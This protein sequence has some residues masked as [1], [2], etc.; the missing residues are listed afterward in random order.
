MVMVRRRKEIFTDRLGI[1]RRINED[2][3]ASKEALARHGYHA[4][5]HAPGPRT[6]WR[7]RPHC[8]IDDNSTQ[9]LAP[10]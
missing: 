7:I 4:I 6:Q 9:R 2:M 10:A 3:L 1:R 8:P 5:P